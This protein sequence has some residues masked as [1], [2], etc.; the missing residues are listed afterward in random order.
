MVMIIGFLL[1][2]VGVSQ[3]APMFVDNY[4]HP[5][6]INPGQRTVDVIGSNPPFQIY[7][8]DIL[9]GGAQIRIYTDWDKLLNGSGPLFARLG[10]VFIYTPQGIYGVAVRDHGFTVYGNYIDEGSFKQGDVF[11]ATNFLKSDYYYDKNTGKVL[12]AEYYQYG[13]NEIVVAN[14]GELL[15]IK[16][17]VSN[18]WGG[19]IG[20]GYIDIIFDQPYFGPMLYLSFTQT[21]ANDVMKV[22]EPAMLILLGSGILGLGIVARRRKK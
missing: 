11:K 8:Y 20:S 3:G 10:D 7:G 12:K 15:P 14:A 4:L 1:T 16:A 5:N 13:D 22:P 6:D 2:I 18:F 19:V 21:C 17:T 9:N